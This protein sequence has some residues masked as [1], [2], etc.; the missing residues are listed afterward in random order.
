MQARS[1]STT[2]VALLSI[3][4][5]CSSTSIVQQPRFCDLK[6]CTRNLEQ[7]YLNTRRDYE[8]NNS[9][10]SPTNTWY[11]T[12]QSVVIFG[13]QFCACIQQAVMNNVTNRTNSSAGVNTNDENNWL[14]KSSKRLWRALGDE[15]APFEKPTST[16]NRR[17]RRLLTFE[18]LCQ[19]SRPVAIHGR[20]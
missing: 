11:H 15:G 4:N 2:V 6:V 14:A 19:E 20:P 7:L 17:V 13:E 1:S 5:C 12:L 3:H 10:S 9:S 16:L 8:Y 18:K